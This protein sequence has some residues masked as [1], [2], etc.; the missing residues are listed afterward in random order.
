[1]PDPAQQARYLCL[2]GFGVVLAGASVEHLADGR[3]RR[4]EARRRAGH[5]RRARC[6]RSLLDRPIEA[7]LSADLALRF[8]RH[9]LLM[10]VG[11]RML[12][13]VAIPH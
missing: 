5:V 2:L 8:A 10:T 3:I 11:S 6:D 4:V 1:M 12:R 13:Y 9:L 7:V